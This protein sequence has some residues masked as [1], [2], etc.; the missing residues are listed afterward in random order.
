MAMKMGKGIGDRG[1]EAGRP[2]ILVI[3][4][5]VGAGHNSVAKAIIQLLSRRGIEAE[6][7]DSLTFTPRWFRAY[8]AGGFA[9]AMTRLAKLYGLGY[10][11]FDRPASAERATSE[12]ARLAM[13]R[14]ATRRLRNFLLQ[15]RPKLII[16][17]HFLAPP[18]IARLVKSGDLSD[19]V[20]MTVLTDIVP[21]RWWYS[22][23]VHHWFLPYSDST[24]P[25]LKWG[26]DRE[27][28]SVCGMMINPKWTDPLPAKGKILA[29]WKLPADK[30]I[31]LLSGGTEFT[32]GPVIKIARR[33]A[34]TRSDVCVV[35]L[36]GRNKRLLEDLALVEGAGE[37]IIGQSFTDRS[38]ELVAVSS[39]MVTKAGGVTTAECISKSCP[40]VLLKPVPGQE[41]MNAEF[42]QRNIAAVIVDKYAQVAATVCGLLGNEGKLSE[43]SQNARRLF[44]YEPQA[45]VSEVENILKTRP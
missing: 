20:Q 2:R 27:K 18:M 14:F 7:V 13:E 35:V 40:M 24:E 42:Y 25:L 10:R 8:Y 6:F 15:R 34:Q 33:I 45:I 21:H 16:N 17:T 23:N 37:K 12:L 39:L 31:V 1:Q 5:S 43:M 36:A 19:T 28:I 38:Q 3:S 9:I 26:I 22:E 4:S 30:K 29:D 32:C 41:G 44:R 11:L